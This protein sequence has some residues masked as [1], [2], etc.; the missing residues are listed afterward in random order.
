MSSKL[1]LCPDCNNYFSRKE[2]GNIDSQFVDQFSLFR[3]LFNIWGDRNS[4]PPTLRNVAEIDG[5]PLHLGPGGTPIFAKS[6]REQLVN[7]DGKLVISVSSPNIEKASEQL[8]HI[9]NQFKDDGVSLGSAKSCKSFLQQALGF[10]LCFGGEVAEKAVLKNLY[11]FLFYIKRNLGIDH[12]LEPSDFIPLKEHLRHNRK[13]GETFASL[14]FKNPHP[15]F[16]EP[17]DISHYLLVSGSAQKNL[18]FGSLVVFGHICFSA[19]L[20]NDFTGDDFS[21]GAK[22]DPRLRKTEILKSLSVPSFD[23][24]IPQNY[25]L[26]AADYFPIMKI[27]FGEMIELYFDEAH[28]KSFEQIIDIALSNGFPKEGELITKDHIDAVTKILESE[29]T[30]YI[31]KVPTEILLD[32][33]DLLIA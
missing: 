8:N 9:K 11:N 26:H 22:I 18:V 28:N 5:C 29:T 17:R 19:V 24:S 15:I 6:I 31:F 14:D 10:N 2:S 12:G 25:P 1:L 27:K 3:N 7:E 4:P 30:R 13:N 16:I 21:Y 20:K 23:P 33:D 32:E